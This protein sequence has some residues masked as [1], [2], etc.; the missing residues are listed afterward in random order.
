[1]PSSNTIAL[2]VGLASLMAIFLQVI[3]ARLGIATGRDLAQCCYEWY[4]KWTRVADWLMRNWRSSACDL[5]EVLG[6]AVD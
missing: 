3:A 1:V 2:V 6:G 5:A 4:P